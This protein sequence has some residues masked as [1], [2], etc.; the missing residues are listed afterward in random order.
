MRSVNNLNKKA[1]NPGPG[2]KLTARCPDNVDAVRKSVRNSPKKSLQRHSQVIW[3][4]SKTQIKDDL[5]QY[6][7]SY[8]WV[9]SFWDSLYLWNVFINFSLDQFK[10]N[11]NL[12]TPR[13]VM[14]NELDYNIEV[15]KFKHQSR[16]PWENYK[17]PYPPQLGEGK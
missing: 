9:A 10:S 14:A 8:Q 7:S 5:M 12:E 1:E 15:N 11:N 17:T 6:E 3:L 16:C 4:L 2:R 13:G